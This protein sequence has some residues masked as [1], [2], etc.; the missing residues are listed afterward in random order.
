[1]TRPIKP[2]SSYTW[3]EPQ[4]APECLEWAN[5]ESILTASKLDPLP[6]TQYV[7]KRLRELISVT[8]RCPEHWIAGKLFRLRKDKLNQQGVLEIADNG[9]GGAQLD[10]DPVVD[11]DELGRQEDRNFEFSPLGFE[12][13]VLGLDA[14]RILL[15]LSNGGSDLVE[16][17]EF[18]VRQR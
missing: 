7:Q 1:M 15:L 2:D 11:I 5:K 10:W 13:R 14:S 18:D 17:R 9:P 3:L 8:I 12:G 16:L 6:H 4:E